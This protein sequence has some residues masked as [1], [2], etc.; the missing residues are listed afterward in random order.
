M[1]L[2]SLF[3]PQPRRGNAMS[4]MGHKVIL[5]HSRRDPNLPTSLPRVILVLVEHGQAWEPKVSCYPVSQSLFTLPMEEAMFSFR[6]HSL[7]T[8]FTLSAKSWG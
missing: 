2:N 6:G 1:Y 5:F 3:K 4:G 8:G 7:T